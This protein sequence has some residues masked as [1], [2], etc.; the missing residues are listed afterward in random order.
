[1]HDP[2]K[3]LLGA[4]NS[5]LKDISHEVGN[6][7]TFVAGLAVR[8]H[9]TGALSLS[10]G[11]LIGVSCGRSLSDTAKTSVVRAGL[12]VPLRLT[13][14]SVASSKK[15]GDITFTAKT[16]GADG[17]NITITL[18]DTKTAGAEEATLDGT[19]ITVAIEGGVST[20]TQVVTAI[21]AV[22][23]IDDLIA[24]VIDEGKESTAQAAATE[25][26]LENGADAFPYAAKGAVVKVGATSGA[27]TSDG[28]ATGAVYVSG[29]IKGVDAL[30][31]TEYDVALIDM[32]GG[33]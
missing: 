3:T 31:G 5:N 11:S 6:P 33:L 12:R 29:P 30:T 14:E 22:D 2:T 23:D 1:M 32:Q 19:D 20:A 18:A 16:A 17:D 13:D 15:I 26:A 8:K 10:S 4:T 25:T 7:A 28:T 24:C 21:E 9:T 27:A